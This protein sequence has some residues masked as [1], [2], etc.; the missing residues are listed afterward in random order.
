MSDK[1]YSKVVISYIKFLLFFIF[2]IFP[3]NISS[4]NALNYPIIKVIQND[5]YIEQNGK[6]KRITSDLSEKENIKLSPSGK[7]LI[8]HNIGKD[9]RIKAIRIFDLPLYNV[10]NGKLNKN[11]KLKN[12]TK[13]INDLDW[14]N[15]N[16]FYT[17][18]DAGNH[19][20][21]FT[22]FDINKIKKR[23]EWHD[24]LY[25]IIGR[26]FSIS[27][28]KKMLIFCNWLD[29]FPDFKEVADNIMAINLE[30]NIKF[31]PNEWQEASNKAVVIYP[32]ASL[33]LKEP[34][35]NSVTHKTISDI[36]WRN[37]NEALFIENYGKN[38][39]LINLRMVNSVKNIKITINKTKHNYI[40]ILS[41]V[42][43]EAKIIIKG[44]T[45]ENKTFSEIF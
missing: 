44:E 36:V 32:N 29:A 33:F 6:E 13:K 9:S 20:D 4:I 23:D 45:E 1:M 2:V 19:H 7:K 26:K 12:I 35:T 16:R 18:G 30:E 43:D 15:N 10:T 40:K 21:I 37:E 42:F 24:S 27:P 17:V 5:I 28:N 38:S 3:L 11:F 14:I 34:N 22:V 41:L 8:F 25:Y 39:S 31:K